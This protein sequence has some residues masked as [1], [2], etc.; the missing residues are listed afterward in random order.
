MDCRVRSI[1]GLRWGFMCESGI[2]VGGFP[3][4]IQDTKELRKIIRLQRD[5]IA[6]RPVF[7][8]LG[9][10][11][12]GAYRGSSEAHGD[13]NQRHS[14]GLGVRL[15]CKTK[16]GHRGKLRDVLTIDGDV[17]ERPDFDGDDGRR[18]AWRWPVLMVMAALQCIPGD[19]N[20]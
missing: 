15:R 14:G 7:F 19:E 2:S 13:L 4:K 3:Q 9:P 5:L 12:D 17:R 8:H 1:K 18:G 10:I 16:R 20:R 11:Q 6:K